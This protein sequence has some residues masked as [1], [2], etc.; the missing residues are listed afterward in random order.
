MTNWARIPAN[1][2]LR[3]DFAIFPPSDHWGQA[4]VQLTSRLGAPGSDPGEYFAPYFIWLANWD[5]LNALSNCTP[6]P[7]WQWGSRDAQFAAPSPPVANV[8]FTVAYHCRSGGAAFDFYVNGVFVGTDTPSEGAGAFNYM[9]LNFGAQFECCQVAYYT[10]VRVGTTEGA[11]DIFADDFS[12]GNLDNWYIQA[13]AGGYPA[14]ASV[15]ASPADD[16]CASI[17]VSPHSAGPGEHIEIV[18]AGFTPGVPVQL[19]WDDLLNGNNPQPDV[20]VADG[21]GAFDLHTVVPLGVSNGSNGTN[22]P[23]AS[24]VVAIDAA[25][26]VAC[27]TVLVCTGALADGIRA[28]WDNPVDRDPTNLPDPL[29]AFGG[30]TGSFGHQTNPVLDYIW[31]DGN[32]WVLWAD[33]SAIVN[34]GTFPPPANHTLN[35][36]RISPDGSSVTDYA[37]DTGYAWQFG[38]TNISDPGL[39]AFWQCP[40]PPLTRPSPV[41]SR[42]SYFSG[43]SKPI[44][45][46]RFASDGSTLWVAVV[47]AESVPYPWIDNKDAHDINPGGAA[48]A[49]P[50][51]VLTSGFSI[52]RT[53]S[54]P[55][56]TYLRYY[57]NPTGPLDIFEDTAFPLTDAGIFGM[58]VWNPPVVAVFASTGAGFMRIGEVDAKYCPSVIQQTDGYTNQGG[59]IIGGLPQDQTAPRGSLYGRVA[60]TASANDPGVCHLVWSEGGDWGRVSDGDGCCDSAAC[61]FGGSRF[62]WDAGPANRSYRVSYTT[63]SPSAKLTDNDIFQSHVDR[64]SWFFNYDFVVGGPADVGYS[65]PDQAD[66]GALLC[67]ELRNDNANGDVLLFAGVTQS[68]PGDPPDAGSVWQDNALQWCDTLHVF[69]ITGGSV[70]LRQS[71]TPDLLPNE[72]EADWAYPLESGSNQPDAT[73]PIRKP[74]CMFAGPYPYNNDF[75]DTIGSFGVQ[76]KAFGI[77]DIYDDP[78]LGGTPVYLVHVPWAQRVAPAE[79][80][81]PHGI[82]PMRGFYRVPADLSGPFDFLDGKRLP[83]F[84]ILGPTGVITWAS[85]DSGDFF[86]DPD[87]IWVPSPTISNTALNGPDGLWF[88]RICA[89]QWEI[90]ENAETPSDFDSGTLGFWPGRSACHGHHYDPASDTISNCAPVTDSTSH[91][92]AVEQLFICRGC[93]TCP[94]GV[95]VHITRRI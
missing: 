46:A 7:C 90:I 73:P 42:E 77:S 14:I 23:T 58:G 26:R 78:L 56:D 3:H 40:L 65:W 16:P 50:L 12:S 95:G 88:D 57:T 15:V 55:G 75:L 61:P 32:H 93:R 18:G 66:F 35:A 80:S 38:Q 34:A 72:G 94:C 89:N 20:I 48:Q 64:T 51:D 19:N 30:S 85:F 71:I 62:V 21:S 41:W 63:W 84:T 36:T 43:W 27:T 69:D 10:D 70:T 28:D 11:S 47:T 25:G 33:D 92:F 9:F 54:G 37:I 53:H 39:G 4:T 82:Y 86:S 5:G 22:F 60:I 8:P 81:P 49:I 2:Q 17:A 45:D 79:P 74:D 13:P 87:N 83:Q 91:L 68:I 44:Y 76:P 59:S 52:F 6:T 1:S 67:Y 24:R 31:H 29:I